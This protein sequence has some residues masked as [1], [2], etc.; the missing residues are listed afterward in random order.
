MLKRI[1]TILS[2]GL[3]LTATSAFGQQFSG[4]GGSG[5]ATSVKSS[6]TVAALPVA[7]ATGTIRIVTDG[8][9]ATD[10]TVGGAATVVFCMYNGAAWAA[11]GGSST[12][13]FSSITT[14]TNTV[15]LHVGNGGTL[16]ATGTGTI[17][18]TNVATTLSASGTVTL[19]QGLT[20]STGNFNAAAF[21]SAPAAL[22]DGAT[23]TWDTSTGQAK[24]LTMVHTQAS[25][26]IN[27]TNLT[28]GFHG[29]LTLIQ[30]ATGGAT[31]V[32]GTG[33][34]WQVSGG[35]GGAIVVTS[36]ANAK[37]KLVFDYDGTNC[38]ASLFANFT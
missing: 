6:P 14:G 25:R 10:C 34:T 12:P 8:N 3:I 29:I 36:T 7:P 28:S 17:T 4:G 27:L 22:T 37:D 23:V 9:S 30:D 20:L 19:N 38:T 18:A 5:T 32:L 21:I 13:A 1:L 15:A 24:T 2:L 33:C 31:I 11:V 16:D 35:G 26:T